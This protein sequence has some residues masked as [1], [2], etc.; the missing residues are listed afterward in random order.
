MNQ[1]LVSDLSYHTPVNEM[2]LA[3]EVLTVLQLGVCSAASELRGDP[4]HVITGKGYGIQFS[5][6]RQC[7]ADLRNKGMVKNYC[8]VNAGGFHVHLT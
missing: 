2:C 3:V 6:V 5:A 1:P 4:I 8:A 7:L